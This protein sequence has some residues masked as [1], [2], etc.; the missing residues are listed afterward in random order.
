[1]YWDFLTLY[2]ELTQCVLFEFEFEQW[3]HGAVEMSFFNKS[4][5]GC[6]WTPLIRA[7]TLT[8]YSVGSFHWLKSMIR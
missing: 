4:S 1:M 2:N 8:S 5:L 3:W 7:R 6:K